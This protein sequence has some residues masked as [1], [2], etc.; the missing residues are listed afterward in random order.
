MKSESD[1]LRKAYELWQQGDELCVKA[2]EDAAKGI[3]LP[4]ETRTEL[5]HIRRAMVSKFGHIEAFDGADM[6]NWWP[7]I[8]GMIRDGYG[9]EQTCEAIAQHRRSDLIPWDD[10]QRHREAAG[11]DFERWIAELERDSES[12]H[13]EPS[14][15]K[16]STPVDLVQYSSPAPGFLS[17]RELA[18]RYGIPR[19]KLNAFKMAIQRWRERNPGGCG[20]GWIEIGDGRRNGEQY[21]Y[22]PESVMDIIN[23]YLPEQRKGQ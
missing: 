14:G 22:S 10:V 4:P 7:W 15:G 11:H 18:D 21:L 23:R 12:E 3:E 20:S 6:S 8:G 16:A 13:T 2:L 19:E 9:L 17:Y 1:Q 5:E